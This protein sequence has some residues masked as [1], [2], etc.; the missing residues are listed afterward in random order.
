MHWR[1]SDIYRRGQKIKPG[2]SGKGPVVYWM[3][4]DQRVADNWSLLW[5]QQE[6]II[7]ER[8]LFV[9][10]C[11][12]SDFPDTTPKQVNFI[13]KGLQPIAKE[14]QQPLLQPNIF[15]QPTLVNTIVKETT[16]VKRAN[17]VFSHISTLVNFRSRDLPEWCFQLM[18]PK[19]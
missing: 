13:L 15:V 9:I 16:L 5:A 19:K 14:L 3:S 1:N 12:T 7:H 11:L 17:Q 4:R 2:K 10:F 8:S 6:A 18:Q